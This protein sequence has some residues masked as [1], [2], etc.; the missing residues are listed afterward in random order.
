MKNNPT[1][2]GFKLWVL[3]DMTGNTV[4]FNVY[5]GKSAERSDRG[6]SHDVVMQLV[7]PLAFQGYEVYPALFEDLLQL[8]ITAT[9]TFR[10]NRRGLPDDVVSLK[11]ALEKGKVSRGTGYYIRDEKAKVVYCVWKD[12]RVVSVMSTAHPGHQSENKVSRHCLDADGKRTMEIPRPIPI[13]YYNHYM[14]VDKSD[15]FLSYHNVL[16]K[17]VRYWKTLFYHMI[18]VG[19]VNAFVLYNHLA[20]LTGCRTVSEN[21]FRDEL[22]LQIIEKYGKYQSQNAQ[23]GQPSR[24]ECRVQHGSTLSLQKTMSVL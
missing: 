11:A 15:Q 21:D 17:T 2:W 10:I 4:D 18:D 7:E 13:E 8:G 1:K 23:P 19:V 22:V 6:F 20:L 9:G 24:S 12:T 3:A 5:T 16:R 14:G